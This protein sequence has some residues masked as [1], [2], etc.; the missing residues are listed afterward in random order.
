MLVEE[1]A[2]PALDT[3]IRLAGWHFV[4]LQGAHSR[5]GVGLSLDDAI[6]QA[7]A[8]A[9]QGLK[10]RFNAAELESV[11]LSS[12]GVFHIA[13]VTLQPRHI[14]QHTTL[15][16]VLEGD[17]RAILNQE[18]KTGVIHRKGKEE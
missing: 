12:Y 13:Q 17:G 1:I 11:H 8:R 18:R 4:C 7:L 3:M 5:S 16:M 14:Q 6:H 10:M 9:L 2:A 15:E